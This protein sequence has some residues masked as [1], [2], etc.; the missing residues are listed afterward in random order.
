MGGNL[1]LLG[2]LSVAVPGELAGYWVAHKAYGKLEW[3][4][5]VVPT[6]ELVEK[7]IPVNAHLANSLQVEKQIILAEPSMR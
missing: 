2:G 1:N 6:A 4:R 7:G 3:N 5:L